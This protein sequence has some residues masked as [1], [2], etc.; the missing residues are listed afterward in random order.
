MQTLKDKSF[1]RIRNFFWPIYAYELK[2][3]VPMFV[4]IF[5][6]SFVYSLLRSFK[7]AIIVTAKGSGAE[8]IS[9]LKLGGVLPGAFLL[10]YIF[11]KLISRFSREQV[12]YT[13]LVGFLTYFTIFLFVLYPNHSSLQLDSVAD[14]LQ[15]LF[16]NKPGLKGL[17]A[18][19]RHLNLSI[20]YVM[21]EMWSVVVLSM[22]FWGFANEVTKVDEAKRFYAIFAL[23]SNAS[24]IFSG[25]LANKLNKIPYTSFIPFKAEDQWMF[26]QLSLILI[27]GATIIGIFYWLNRTVFH[28]EN[29]QS[30]KIPKKDNK[31][32]LK[33]CFQYLWS[34]KYLRCMVIVI[35]SYNVVY[36]LADN[37]W[38]FKASQIYQNP[39]DFNFYMNQ[40]V[41]ATGIVSVFFAFIVS[42][43]SIRYYGWTFTALITPVIWLLTSIG[44]FSGLIFDGTIFMDIVSTYIANPANFFLLLGGIQ[45]CF[46]RACKYTVFDET[47]EI[48]FIPLSKS[49]KRKGKAIVDGLASR[50]GKSGG[51][52]IYITLFMFIGDFTSII[53]YV[54]VIMLV[55]IVLWIYAVVNLG[56]LVGHKIDNKV[57]NSRKKNTDFLQRPA[58]A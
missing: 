9:F 17:I 28:L 8:V 39:K 54:A 41:V 51:A 7:V 34:S 46:G 38:T 48:A 29:V 14:Y 40:I 18:V 2:K 35:I 23:G 6:I 58:E 47:K 55:A 11:T 30:L 12:F 13:M 45:M 15:L 24:G 33:E 50:F 10:T 31:L 57:V 43:N 22:L 37:M 5:M 56:K 53:P 27:L 52:L 3:L 36:N 20:F 19:I 44:F 1:G 49:E 42:G 4:L 16:N 32:S 21:S 25:I 26:Y